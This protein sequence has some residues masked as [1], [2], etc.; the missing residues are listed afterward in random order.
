MNIEDNIFYKIINKTA[1]ANIVYEN[2]YVCC[3]EDI[4]PWCAYTYSNCT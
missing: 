2:D 1:D 3:F 4:E